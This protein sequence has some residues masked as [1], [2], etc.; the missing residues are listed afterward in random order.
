MNLSGVI[1]RVGR[2]TQ[3]HVRT[4]RTVVAA[5]TCCNVQFR[6]LTSTTMTTIHPL[7]ILDIPPEVLLHIFSYL[8]LPDLAA[9]AQASPILAA[10]AADP[11]LHRNRVRIVAPSRV[12]HSLFGS[13]PHGIA[14][15]PTVGELI[16]RGVM[17]G[18]GIERRWRMGAY[19]YSRNSITQYENGL[20]LARRHASDVVSVQL[21]RRSTR[22]K[23]LDSIAHVLPDVESASHTISRILLPVIH[24]LK[25]SIQRDSLARMVRLDFCGIPGPDGRRFGEWRE[26]K[27]HGIVQDG[28]RVRLA[29]C[30]D[31]RKTVKFYEELTQRSV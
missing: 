18:F 3:T 2:V 7:C 25:W 22:D 16:H 17:R 30:P 26:K 6:S 8:D 28:E 1:R 10:L 24:Q 19:F 29:I 9:L 4:V 21:R 13:S 15:R 31:V 20:R 14:F 5:A 11:I 12:K 27:G 23:F